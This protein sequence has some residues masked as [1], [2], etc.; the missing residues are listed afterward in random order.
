MKERS[1]LSQRKIFCIACAFAI[2]VFT[3]FIWKNPNIVL[4]AAGAAL[5]FLAALFYIKQ[6][7]VIALCILSFFLGLWRCAYV[8]SQKLPPKGKY[9]VSAEVEGTGSLSADGRRARIALKNVKLFDGS[10]NRYYAPKAYLTYYLSK[11]DAVL[12]FDG[13]RIEFSS[14]L[15]HPSPAQNPYGFDFR[16]YLLQKGIPIGLSGAKDM[17][18]VPHEIKDHLN[19]FVRLKLS[20]A[21]HIDSVFGENSAMPKALLLGLK[22]GIDPETAESFRLAG[23]AHLLA[24]SGLHISLLVYIL[25]RVF[26]KLKIRHSISNIIILLFLAFY[27]VFLNFSSSVVRASLMAA[28]LMLGKIKKRRRD[29]LT[30]LSSAFLI[31][32]IFKPLELFSLGF[33]LSFLAVLGIILFGNFARYFLSRRPYRKRHKIWLAYGISFGAALFTLP[34]IA[35]AFHSVPFVSLLFGPITALAAGVLIPAY[36]F[37]FSLSFMPLANA[38]ALPAGFLTRLFEALTDIAAHM[39]LS[40]VRLPAFPW[41]FTLFYYTFLIML[42]RYVMLNFKQKAAALSSLALFCAAMFAFNYESGVTYTMFS[43]GKGD[44]ACIEDKRNCY[45]IDTGANASDLAE[46][47]LSRGKNVNAVFISHLH[48]DHAGGLEQLIEKGVNI[49]KIYLSHGAEYAPDLKQTPHA[50]A[51]AKEKGI[52]ISYLSAGDSLDFGR[53]KFSVLWP[54]K[55]RM[56][57]LLPLNERSM[58]LKISLDNVDLLSCGDLGARYDKYAASPVHVLKASHHGSKNASS[59]EFL[60]IAQPDYALVSSDAGSEAALRHLQSKL[61]NTKIIASFSNGAIKIICRDGKARIRRF[62]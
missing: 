38:L 52:P 20:A 30:S 55:N 9:M 11:N 1:F 32:L 37:I 43:V 60:R 33:Q 13:Q 28:A 54:H 14:K 50:L 24:I 26:S 3:G 21:K 34:P 6:S 7:A 39:S 57:E 59:E 46:Y 17:R 56:H 53:V 4:I 19:P 41:Y 27:C 35:N 42:S 12:P 62:N 15:Y 16:L 5:S 49:D 8:N 48:A 25:S 47:I 22:D 31:I 18:F 40:S 51:L 29:A 23:L 58:A 61:K 2:G 45:I 44:S 36:L 10:E